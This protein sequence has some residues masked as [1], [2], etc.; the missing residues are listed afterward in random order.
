MSD[1][2]VE[3]AVHELQLDL[4]ETTTRTARMSI[5]L[6]A[7]NA[8]ALQRLHGQTGR[9]KND[10]IN[11]A[12]VLLANVHPHLERGG[13]LQLVTADGETVQLMLLA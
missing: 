6:P 13:K 11:A 12:L 10:L 2:D 4:D 3:L 5:T 7:A 8:V 1:E 9:T